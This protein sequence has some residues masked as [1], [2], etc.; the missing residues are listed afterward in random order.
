MVWTTGWERRR[1]GSFVERL[2][3]EQSE[4]AVEAGGYGSTASE[5]CKVVARE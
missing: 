4:E 5:A 3:S 2:G 1:V